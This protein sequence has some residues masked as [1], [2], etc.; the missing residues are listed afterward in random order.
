MEN[1]W[2]AENLQVIRTLMERS[3]VYRRALAPVMT[4]AGAVGVAAG[5]AGW[6]FGWDE[7]KAF[8]AYW[9][10]VA[11]A[12]TIF[13]LGQ[14]R[15][16]AVKE[17]E[18]FWS[19]PTRRVALAAFPAL[20]IGALMGLYFVIHGTHREAVGT[21]V[22]LW[23]LFYGCALHAAG[24]FIPRGI[25]WVGWMF[26]LAGLLIAVAV[27]FGGMGGPGRCWHLVMGATFGG[28]HLAYGVYLYFTEKRKNAA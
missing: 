25:R 27:T 9:L 23:L 10:A 20:M 21:L 18:P 7:P 2:A 13:S 3:A 22:I 26:I 15:R 6:G 28:L 5:M 16:Q 24:F 8:A 17:G 1:N 14:I 4:V 12:S 19:P 11:A